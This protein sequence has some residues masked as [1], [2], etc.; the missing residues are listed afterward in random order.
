MMISADFTPKKWTKDERVPAVGDIC[1]I[2]R[3]L[4]T[5]THMTLLYLFTGTVSPNNLFLLF[6]LGEGLV[7]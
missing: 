3:Q 4:V 7:L 5:P 1:F 2:T 6:N